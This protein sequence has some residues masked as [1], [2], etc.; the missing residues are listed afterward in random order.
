MGNK[1]Q[2]FAKMSRD[3]R[4]LINQNSVISTQLKEVTAQRDYYA[5]LA[6]QHLKPTNR[7]DFGTAIIYLKRGYQVYR[8]GWNGKDMFLTYVEADAY[9]LRNYP[10]Q[11][12]LPFIALHTADK[13][14]VPWLASQTDI[15]STDWCICVASMIP[16]KNAN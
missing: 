12:R 7:V 14:M 6:C 8:D 1:L 16:E 5:E 15:L 3:V 11:L 9:S 10:D 2:F 13:K 4:D